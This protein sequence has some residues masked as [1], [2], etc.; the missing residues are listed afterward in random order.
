MTGRAVSHPG[1]HLNGVV[2]GWSSAPAVPLSRFMCSSSGA[3]AA[4]ACTGVMT[5]A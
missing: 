3:S 4:C 1:S 5:Q 2:M